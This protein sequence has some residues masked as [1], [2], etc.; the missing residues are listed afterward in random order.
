SLVDNTNEGYTWNATL[1]VERPAV[2]GLGFSL[3]YS[4]TRA[5]ALIDGRGFI[6]ATNW[7]QS[8]SL[9]GR[10][11][12][13]VGR[14]TF[15]VGSRLVG[16]LSYR[17]EYAGFMATTV[18]LFYNGQSGEPF[19]YVY[20]GG[21]AIFNE[22]NQDYERSLI[23]V[24]ASADEITLGQRGVVDVIIDA[25]GE[26][27]DVLGGVPFGEAEQQAMYAELDAYIESD[28][29]LSERRGQYAEQNKSRVPFSSVFDLKLLQDF[30]ITTGNGRRHTLQ[31]S[32][33]VF[34]VSNLIGNW[35]NQSWGERYF[36]GSGDNRYTFELLQFEGFEYEEG[37]FTQRPV[38]SFQDPNEPWDIDQR[39]NIEGSRWAAQVGLRY[40]F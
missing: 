20:R 22:D 38:F 37:E 3:A 26:E 29:H 2:N 30:Y 35:F 32:L 8:F 19:S 17:K 23:Y 21:D 13:M 5:E 7:R 11:N 31:L 9:N 10:N 28:D 39:A 15:D 27:N 1:K 40:T 16:A 12:P 33:D 4:F 36:I 18:S 25:E 24:P 6:N 14:S 34:N